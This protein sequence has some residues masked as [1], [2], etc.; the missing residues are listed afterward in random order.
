MVTLQLRQIRI[1][2]GQSVS[3]EDVSWHEFEMILEELG[4]RRNTRISYNNK[5]LTIVA[6]LYE[7][8]SS[9]VTLG[10]MVKVLLEE[11]DINY[12]AAGSTTLKRQDIGKGA[13]PDDSFYIA[14]CE[15][16]LGKKTIDLNIDPPPDLAIEVDLTSKTQIDIYEAL[17]VPELWR[18][19]SGQLRIDILN[20]GQYVR[21][22]RS[23]IFP[24][25]PI[26]ELAR[27]YVDKAIASGQGIATKELRKWVR[28]RLENDLEGG[29]E[30]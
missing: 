11:L 10:D 30:Y 18:F 8:E 13:E 27:K 7:H 21:V 22:E 15:Q 16:V 14:S 29:L 5:V 20:D 4:D 19:D 6:P 25:W 3:L 23:R 2:P 17:G 1:L 28:S 26:A 24:D 9:K 12:A